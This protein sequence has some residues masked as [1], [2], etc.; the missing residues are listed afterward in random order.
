MKQKLYRHLASTIDAYHTCVK[1][2]NE[3]WEY[4]HHAVI[5]QIANNHLPH[6]SGIDSG[7]EVDLQ[8]SSGER[9]VITSSY[10]CMNENGMYDGWADFTVTVKASLVHTL[11]M[12]VKSANGCSKQ[13]A[14]YDLGDYL[15]DVFY[16][17][18]TEEVDSESL[19]YEA[20]I[21]K[22]DPDKSTTP[23]EGDYQTSDHS[24]FY[25]YGKLVLTV[26]ADASSG[27]MWQAI[28]SHMEASQYWP[29]VWF[30]SDHGNCHLMSEEE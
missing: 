12:T 25:Q 14:K 10:H 11:D 16:T 17:S 2:G 20:G 19:A 13:F 22:K 15:H 4:N 27:E 29:N 6:G 28:K 26:D 5:C 24:K 18:L 1:A 3:T 30:I 21:I 9:I 8:C 23:E 7:C